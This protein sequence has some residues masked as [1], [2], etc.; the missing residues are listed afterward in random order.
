MRK[1]EIRQLLTTTLDLGHP[2]GRRNRLILIFLLHT[3]IRPEECVNLT[4]HQGAFQGHPR[5]SLLLPAAVRNGSRS[6]VVI[7]NPAAQECVRKILDF[8]ASHGFATTP[9]AP[10]FQ[11]FQRRSISVRSI[12]AYR[13][14]PNSRPVPALI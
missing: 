13:K 7:L 8:N 6:Q 3:G 11:D 4:I 14:R 12:T 10:L 9:N 5:G 2:L 1:A